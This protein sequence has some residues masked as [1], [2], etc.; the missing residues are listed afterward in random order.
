[1]NPFS[2]D[3]DR[4]TEW[5]TTSVWNRL[6][7]CPIEVEGDMT[8][9]AQKVMMLGTQTYSAEQTSSIISNCRIEHPTRRIFL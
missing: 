8:D 4:I 6:L 5:D 3:F 7:E 1:M 2:R 9:P